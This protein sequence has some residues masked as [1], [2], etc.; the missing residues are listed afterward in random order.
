[1]TNGFTYWRYQAGVICPLDKLAGKMMKSAKGVHAERHFGIF[2]IIAK[3]AFDSL[4][5][6]PT[7]DM[8]TYS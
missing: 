8:E 2:A 3:S 5:P 4:L 1:L 7:D 6:L